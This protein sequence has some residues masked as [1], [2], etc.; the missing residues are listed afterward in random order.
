[1]IHPIMDAIRERFPP[2][3]GKAPSTDGPR[4][5]PADSAL[6]LQSS[7]L[8]SEAREP[9]PQDQSFGYPH[10]IEQELHTSVDVHAAAAVQFL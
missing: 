3:L 5:D 10:I 6:T 4:L 9:E 7:V 8:T 2:S 1:M